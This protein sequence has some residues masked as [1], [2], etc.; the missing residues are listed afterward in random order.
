MM[1]YFCIIYCNS[2]VLNKNTIKSA[3]DSSE[4]SVIYST[5]KIQRQ[6]NTFECGK[7]GKLFEHRLCYSFRFCLRNTFR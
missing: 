1:F 5:T 6:I 4:I 3:Q 2:E 7:N